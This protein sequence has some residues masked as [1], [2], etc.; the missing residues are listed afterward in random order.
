LQIAGNVWL[1]RFPGIIPV[2]CVEATGPETLMKRFR[3]KIRSYRPRVSNW[4]TSMVALQ[5]TRVL[6]RNKVAVPGQVPP[7]VAHSKMLS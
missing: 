6:V 1:W 4:I 7:A 3:G 2:D 5:H